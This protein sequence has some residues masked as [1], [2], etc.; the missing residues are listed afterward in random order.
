MIG[1]WL[2]TFVVT[3]I[4]V[5][6]AML[7][8]GIGLLIVGRPLRSSCGGTGGACLCDPRNPPCDVLEEPT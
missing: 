8:L 4:A 7:G 1:P 5:A 2:G 3:L 6:V